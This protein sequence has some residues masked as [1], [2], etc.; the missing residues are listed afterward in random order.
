MS[1][2]LSPHLAHFLQSQRGRQALSTAAELPLTSK[3]LLANLQ[4]LRA[5]LNVDEA[6]AVVEQVLLRRKGQKKFA[7][8]DQMLFIREALE[9]ATHHLVATHRAKRF[10]GFN[11]VG[12]LGCGIGGDT[13]ALA[14]IANAVTA[15]DLD[16]VRLAFAR[17]NAAVYNLAHKLTFVQ[18]NVCQLPAMMSS[19]DAYFADPARR[20][21]RGTRVSNP[22]NYQPP[23]NDLLTTFSHKPLAIKVAP[24]FRYETLPYR[25]EVEA[26]SLHGEVKEIILWF[27]DLATP[28][29]ARRATL[30]PSQTVLTNDSDDDCPNGSYSTYLY[31][32]DAAIIRAG[33]VKN[34][35]A[36]LDLSQPDL[37]IAYLTGQTCIHH[38]FVKTYQ[39]EATLPLKP[40]VINRYLKQHHIDTLDFKQRGTGIALDTFSKKIKPMGGSNENKRT[41]ILTRQQDKHLAFICQRRTE[42][43]LVTN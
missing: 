17:H 23:L 10:K 22:N 40:K 8:A 4:T 43:N 27:H 1:F 14:T 12:D 37:H 36:A 30:L 35:A 29:I 3:H 21:S 2:Q 28:N 42:V 26:I 11:R 20:S 9:Q 13:I 19:L 41:L 25:G 32:P 7:Q 15:F 18:A 31:E 38:P 16:P 39:I 34:A 24:G 6:S 33:L 5:S